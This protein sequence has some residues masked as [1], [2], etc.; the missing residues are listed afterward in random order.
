MKLYTTDGQTK[1]VGAIQEMERLQS[2]VGGYFEFVGYD[3]GV[4]I[5][6]E[7]ARVKNLPYNESASMIAG[8]PLFGDVLFASQ[9]EIQ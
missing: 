7:E 9:S 8:F 1:D 2:F 3:S 6:N 4:V 5:C